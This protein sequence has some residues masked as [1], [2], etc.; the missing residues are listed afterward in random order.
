[1]SEEETPEE[2]PTPSEEPTVEEQPSEA[3]TPTEEPVVEEVK[4]PNIFMVGSFEGGR[5]LVVLDEGK[6]YPMDDFAD[7]FVREHN[8]P[9]LAEYPSDV[10]V[11]GS[12]RAADLVSLAKKLEASK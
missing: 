6:A 5:A 11:E 9:I 3:P 2:Q 1:M 10:K 7:K 12:D 4:I 8:I